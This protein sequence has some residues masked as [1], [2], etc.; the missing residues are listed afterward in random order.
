MTIHPIRIILLS[1][2]AA[3]PWLAGG[4]LKFHAPAPQDD[5][6][7]AA[8]REI[9]SS[10]ATIQINPAFGLGVE[11]L[12]EILMNATL[13]ASFHP[14]IEVSRLLEDVPDRAVLDTQTA[15]GDILALRVQ[16]TTPASACRMNIIK[17]SPS[18]MPPVSKWRRKRPP[19]MY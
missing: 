8:P 7:K 16:A 4:I 12:Q 11:G 13:V 6:R 14:K 18:S 17:E 15:G 19:G 2:F 5:A 9:Y 3:A 1:A 10:A